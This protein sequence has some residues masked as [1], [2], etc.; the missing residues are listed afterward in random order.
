MSFGCSSKE[1]EKFQNRI[2][3]TQRV[4]SSKSVPQMLLKN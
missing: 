3:N 2:L 4:K 1:L